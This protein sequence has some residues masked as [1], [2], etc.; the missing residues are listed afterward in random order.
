LKDVG[1][2]IGLSLFAAFAALAPT[3]VSPGEG[4]SAPL[5]DTS[6]A[7][8]SY[9]IVFS[10]T[11]NRSSPATLSGVT[12]SGNVYVFTSPDTN[13]IRRVRFYLDNPSATGKPRRTENNA[14]YDFAGGTEALANPFDTRTVADGPHTIAA[15]IDFLDGTT[16][17]VS[18]SFTVRNA[19]EAG[20]AFNP[21][22]VSFTA[23]QGA[24]PSSDTSQLG[25]SDGSV[26][27]FMV[28][29]DATWLTVSPASG[30]T[31]ATIAVTADPAGLA[32]G[33]YTGTVTATASGY[34]STQLTVTLTVATQPNLAFNPTSLAFSAE[35][36]GSASSQTS[37]LTTSNGSAAS[38]TV[39]ENATWLSA[40][41]TSGTTPATLTFTANPTGLAPGTYSETVTAT[42]SGYTSAQ[43]TV[44]LTVT[45][46]PTVVFNPTSLSFTAQQGGSSSS[47]SSQVTTSDGSSASFT[48]AENATWLTVGPASG[49]T[50][51]TITVTADPT[52]LA[53]GTY[54]ETVTATASGYTASSLS[55]TLTVTAASQYSLLASRLPNRSSPATLEGQSFVRGADIFVF[56]MPESGVARVR[57]YLDDPA[58][59]GSPRKIE[60]AA[61]YDFNGTASDGSAVPFDTAT[62]AAGSH[63]VTAAIEKSAGGTDVLQAQFTVSGDAVACLPVACEDILVDLPYELD[64][65]TDHRFV[66]DRNG[67][68]T[69]FTYVDG[70][71]ARYDP[72]KL[73]M[74]LPNSALK[75]ET[76][77]GIMTRNVDTQRNALAVGIAAP[78]QVSVIS[79]TLVN[80]PAGTGNYEQAGL[81]FGND[82]DNYVKLTVQSQPTGTRIQLYLELNGA[83]A[84][85][86]NGGTFN[87][88]ASRVS[89]TLRANPLN[90]TVTGSFRIGNGA[91]ETRATVTVPGEF[92][93]FDA[94]GIDPRIGTRS[95]GG[96][97]ATHRFGPGPLTYTFDDFSVTAAPLEP[98]VGSGPEFT[99][100]SFPIPNPTSM[101][102]GPDGRLYVTE[103]MGKVHA[104]TLDD[105]GQVVS[106]TVST[107]L[108][109]R[110]TLGLTTGPEST[111]SDVVVYV[112]HSSPSLDNGV[113]N[114]GVISRLT[115]PSL[116]ARSDIITGIPRAKANHGTNKIR[117]GP[118]GKLYIAQGGNT[119]AG[120][121]NSAN[122]E[123]GAMEEQPLSAALLI[124]DVNAPGF[125]GTCANETDIFGPPPCDVTV[126]AS[127]LRNTYDFVF[128]SNGSI[129]GP[130]NGL[131]VTGTFPPSPTP[132]CFGF[133]DTR[134]W[135]EGGDNPGAQPD[136]LNRIVQGGYYG[137]PNPYRNECVFMDGH[138]QGVSP[139]PN[140]KPPLAN[141]GSNASA[142]GT[143]EYTSAAFCAQLKGE[144]LIARYSVGDDIRRVKLSADGLSVVSNN[145]LASGFV[146]PLPLAMGPNG[147]IGVGELGASR[148]TLLK[149]VD[150]GCWVSKA[151][152]PANLLDVGGAALNGKV[153]IVAGK[154]SAG[155]RSDV[156]VYDPG[157][158]TWTAAAPL[159]GPAVE[160]PAVVAVG[161]KLYAFGGSTFAFSGAVTNAA[162]YDPAQNSWTPLAGMA[163]GR[164][165]AAA[166]AIGTK[167]Y[168]AGGMGGDGASLASVEVFD[169]VTQTWS[170]APAMSTRR[171]NPAAAVADGKLY[172]FGGRTRNADG[173]TV[174]GTLNT[175]E[176]FDPAVGAWSARAPMPTGRR[177]M[178]VGRIGGKVQ[179]MGGEA[180]G[181]GSGV[182]DAN[183]EY[184]P[185]TDTWRSLTPMKTPRH[186][187]AAGTINGVVYVA[188]G[189][190]AAGSSF[191]DINEAFSFEG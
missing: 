136:P 75:I 190:S 182:F 58:M 37:Q 80:P 73:L 13:D 172:I 139:L 137:H 177:T 154:T 20:L 148:V 91:E 47:Q 106:D 72:A 97:F 41:P 30:T 102:W 22:S 155:P 56:T 113:P 57:Y 129:Y 168:V 141:L 123:F 149:P 142:N 11:S 157:T 135:E 119:G 7:A 161:D 189:G 69:G 103:L 43:L 146:D 140:W 122:S 29:D 45:V 95:F 82:D 10:L 79:T 51:A 99:R 180:S 159:P 78:N 178:A 31:P 68:G 61:P 150:K 152:L 52:G 62:V 16:Q 158:D 111:P 14:P 130:D 176:M 83:T 165:G 138:F 109:T 171:D 117:F 53:A 25:S 36:G 134:S 71:E 156:L 89:L 126:Y 54:A 6:V 5:A 86:F 147:W 170:S 64:F 188:G 100:A 70:S 96:I 153:Y 105:Q 92:F 2:T 191:T 144:L 39:A 181:V 169:T 40:S 9:D 163:T 124:A 15:A 132:P 108:G 50:P 110:L 118:D 145:Q 175:V 4:R 120:A 63:T 1:R 38:F 46:K 112:S 88:S 174:N 8:A 90:R 28:A 27:S 151:P 18:A 186:G 87:L 167:I 133:G 116:A 98:P 121:P 81:W 107:A 185:A 66:A 160:N 187:A 49:T 162:V 84:V 125:D 26:A 131:G 114:S 48:V 94:A 55:V 23:Q 184:D 67:V 42:A 166:A 77:A 173:T 35:Q 104:L 85:E 33:T 179:L 74:D 44:T 183:E 65:S 34:T 93:S 21:T 12:I 3:L 101:E 127:G 76:T 19:R 115:G 17:V 128:H 32:A 164:G 24:S 59:S 60:S 143:I